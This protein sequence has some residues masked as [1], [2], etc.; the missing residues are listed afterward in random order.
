MRTR[1]QQHTS[2]VNGSK[3]RGPT[4]AQGRHNAD[5]AKLQ[6]GL[7]AKSLAIIPGEN[8]QEAADFVQRLFDELN[9]LGELQNEIFSRLATACTLR[10]R[11]DRALAAKLKEQVQNALDDLRRRLEEEFE[12]FRELFRDYP[13]KRR[14]EGLAGLRQSS[15]GCLWLIQRWLDLRSALEKYGLLAS[16]ELREL[17]N[18]LDER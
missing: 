5:Q 11:G 8:A 15:L 17:A 10:R 3:S 16:H 12:H 1:L 13:G 18:L 7:T 4:S 6:H 14:A 9:P 2:R